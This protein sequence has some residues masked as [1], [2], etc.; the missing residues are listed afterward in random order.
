M[1]KVKKNK[2]GRPPKV[3]AVIV[4]KLI[5]GFNNGFNIEECCDYSGIHKDTYYEWIKKNKRFADDMKSARM[6]LGKKSKKVLSEE[7]QNGNWKCA[8]WWLERTQRKEFASRTELTGED[9]KQFEG[10]IIYA[11]EKYP[12]DNKA[13]GGVK[14]KHDTKLHQV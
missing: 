7:I 9:G 4:G 10:V 6:G 8:R 3:D 12:V 13:S 1:T 5:A 14:S 2:G 11:P